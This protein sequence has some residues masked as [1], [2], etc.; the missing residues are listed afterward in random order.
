MPNIKAHQIHQCYINVV[1]LDGQGQG[2][3]CKVLGKIVRGG[4][5][6]GAKRISLV[7]KQ[8]LTSEKSVFSAIIDITDI[9]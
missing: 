2:T 9:Q 7:S 3:N 5:F 6:F 4:T 8:S 1:D